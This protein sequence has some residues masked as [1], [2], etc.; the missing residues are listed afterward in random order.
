[1]LCQFQ[2]QINTHSSDASAKAKG[3]LKKMQSTQFLKD[4]AMTTDIVMRLKKASL[5]LQKNKCNIAD[6]QDVVK[7]AVASLEKLKQK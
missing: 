2:L 6:C 1:M 4:A 5:F 3:F 7:S